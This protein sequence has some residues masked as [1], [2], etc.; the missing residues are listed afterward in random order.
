M[1]VG[2]HIEPFIRHLPAEHAGKPLVY[3]C[4]T[5]REERKTCPECARKVA[6]SGTQVVKRAVTIYTAETLTCGFCGVA[7]VTGPALT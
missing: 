5:K 1:A 4:G 3:Y 7:L 6:E 2:K